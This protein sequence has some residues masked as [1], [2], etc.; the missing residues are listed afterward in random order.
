[1]S[2][3]RRLVIQRLQAL[4][5][6]GVSYLSVPK[7][8]LDV[9]AAGHGQQPGQ[10]PEPVPQAASAPRPTDSGTRSRRRDGGQR[11]AERVALLLPDVDVSAQPK[12]TRPRVKP[13]LEAVEGWSGEKLSTEQKLARLRELQQRVSTCTRCPVLVQSRT[14][15]V[16]GVG[17]PDARLCFVGEAPGADEDRLGEP[18]VGRAGQLLNKMIEAM[19]LRRSDV[20]ICN[21]IK[22]RPPQNRTPDLTEVRNCADFLD[23]QLNIIQPE[24]ICALGSVAAKRLL[25]P[26][27]AL[28]KAR[29]RLF[30]YLGAKVIV[31][32]HPAYLLRN[33]NAKR[34]AWADLQMLMREMGLPVPRGRRS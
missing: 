24:F 4:R 21:V 23:E 15:T 1:M 29:G 7:R 19:G 26:A 12:Q 31:T 28:S 18:F 10:A 11:R 14:Q 16:F 6:A 5:R 22:C 33:P 30:H 27:T 8:G 2:D 32:Y 17:N 3:T 25:G 9:Q 34:D 13:V 20:Y